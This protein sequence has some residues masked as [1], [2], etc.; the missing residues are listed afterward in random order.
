M[1][2]SKSG[3]A[4]SYRNKSVYTSSLSWFT[5]KSSS[6]PYILPFLDCPRLRFIIL[7]FTDARSG[8]TSSRLS[9]ISSFRHRTDSN[10]FERSMLSPMKSSFV[11]L[12][13]AEPNSTD[14]LVLRMVLHRLRRNFGLW[15]GFRR[16]S[17][18]PEELFRRGRQLLLLR[19]SSH[20]PLGF[21]SLFICRNRRPLKNQFGIWWLWGFLLTGRSLCSSI[22]QHCS[23]KYAIEYHFEVIF[24]VLVIK[25]K[26]LN[27]NSVG[28][29]EKNGFLWLIRFVD[30]L[31]CQ[32]VFSDCVVDNSSKCMQIYVSRVSSSVVLT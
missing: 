4:I 5:S 21:H 28:V 9:Q 30:D 10:C 7:F 12:W 17:I 26:K 14:I 22:R 2:F 8:I 25:S 6:K 29:A 13:R 11:M 23:P 31:P 24:Y 18:F 27:K 16:C 3:S 1:R 19:L 32:K 20:G 15:L